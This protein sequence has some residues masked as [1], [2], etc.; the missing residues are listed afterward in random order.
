MVWSLR[1]ARNATVQHV[2]QNS[3]SASL[4]SVEI[5]NLPKTIKP[6]QMV[7]KL[8]EFLQSKVVDDNRKP[9][10]IVDLQVVLPKKIENLRLE[11]A[12]L[13]EKAYYYHQLG[14][15]FSIESLCY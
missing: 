7:P 4:Y 15:N 12:H 1:Y 9:Y 5:T 14:I 13:C 6:E 10:E 2:L 11:Y 8:W 3:Y